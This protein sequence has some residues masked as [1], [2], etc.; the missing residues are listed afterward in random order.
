MGSQA[1]TP[2]TIAIWAGA[3]A[4]PFWETKS[5]ATVRPMLCS[6]VLVK[7]AFC[8]ICSNARCRIDLA[9]GSSNHGAD[10]PGGADA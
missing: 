10:R 5:Q 1:K 3:L 4:R 2:W 7:L 6:E 8:V 9:V